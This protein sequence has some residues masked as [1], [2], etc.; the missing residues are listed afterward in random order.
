MLLTAAVIVRPA[1]PL[2]GPLVVEGTAAGRAAE[3]PPAPIC[4]VREADLRACEARAREAAADL[5]AARADAEVWAPLPD[6]LLEL[7]IRVAAGSA[8]HAQAP[9]GAAAP[10]GRDDGLGV[11]D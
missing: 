5:R 3:P 11:R 9:Q 10:G 4:L 8:R 2:R 6:R 7:G 1:E